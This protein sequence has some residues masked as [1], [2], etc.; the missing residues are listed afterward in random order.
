MQEGLL[1]AVVCT[2][3]SALSETVI[4]RGRCS[5]KVNRCARDSYSLARTLKAVDQAADD[6]N[7]LILLPPVVVPQLT[8]G[9]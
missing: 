9:Q 5:V 6:E 2:L 8:K 7:T 1:S 4:S 3:F